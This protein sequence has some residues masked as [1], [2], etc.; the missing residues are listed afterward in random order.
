MGADYIPE[1]NI[2]AR[3]NRERTF[4]LIRQCVDANFNC[5]RVWGGGLYPS[6]DFYDA[7]DEMGLVVWQDFMFA[8]ANYRLTRSFEENILAELRDNVRRL[9]HHA[10][11]GLWCGN[12]EME[13]FVKKGERGAKNEIRS[14]YVKMYEYL[15][16]RLLEKTAL[17]N[18]VDI[19]KI[20]F[21]S[22]DDR[23]FSYEKLVEMKMNGTIPVWVDESCLEEYMKDEESQ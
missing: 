14:D 6:D 21:Y 17:G 13:M 4:R 18:A 9:R 22:E 15:F 11:L 23:Y 10:S 1:D 16:P 5:I 2:L 12:N 3:T 7:C 19:E 8:C 20:N